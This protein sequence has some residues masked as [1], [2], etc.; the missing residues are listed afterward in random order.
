MEENRCLEIRELLATD[1][2]GNFR[3]IHLQNRRRIPAFL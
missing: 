3:G 2:G 1:N